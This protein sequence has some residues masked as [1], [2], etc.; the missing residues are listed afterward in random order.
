MFSVPVAWGPWS[1]WGTCS[2]TCDAGI[3]HRGRLCNMPFS[4][5]NNEKCVGDSTEERI[6]VQRACA[7]II[8]KIWICYY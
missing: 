6:C 7:G 1:E 8:S 5:R 3:Q 2:S 4:K